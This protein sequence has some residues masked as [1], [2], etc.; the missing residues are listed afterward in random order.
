MSSPYRRA[1]RRRSVARTLAY[2]VFRF[3]YRTLRILMVLAAAIG[4]AMPPPPP[5]P[6]PAIEQVDEEGEVLEKR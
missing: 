2:Y 5:P 1:R 6:P 4:P 3:I